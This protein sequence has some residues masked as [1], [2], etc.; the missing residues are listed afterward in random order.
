MP[1]TLPAGTENFLAQMGGIMR[2]VVL[3]DIQ[4]TDGSQFFW[5]DLEGNYLSEMTGQTQFYNG[6]LKGGTAFQI[7]KDLSTNAGDMT[8]QNIS[9]NTI[10]RDVDLALSNHEFEGALCIMR[11]WMP[12]LDAA[13][14]EFHGQI[15]EQNPVED[16]FQF[17]HLQLFDPAQYDAA[18]DVIQ[19]LCTWRYQSAQCGSTGSATTCDF[20]LSTCQDSQHLA[21]ERFNGVLSIVPVASLFNP[22]T[23]PKVPRPYPRVLR[24][25][26]SSD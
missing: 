12:I 23:N 21:Q 19:D 18:D 17:R 14:D 13:I 16:E 6:W 4:T 9:G 10:D 7:T 3:L 22:T 20:K 24:N 15:S 8:V 2:P 26:G 11:V 1:R 25:I 5:A